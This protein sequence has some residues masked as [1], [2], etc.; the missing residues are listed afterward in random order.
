MNEESRVLAALAEGGPYPVDFDDD[1]HRR[2]MGAL[3]HRASTS[4]DLGVLMRHLLRRWMLR[5]GRAVPVDVQADVS[6]SLREVAL[7][8]GLLETVP[9]RWTASTWSPDW[10]DA[11]GAPCD[12]AALAGTKAGLRFHEDPLVADPFFA[13]LTPFEKYRTAG[14]RAACRAAISSPEGATVLCMLPTGSGKT[15]I[16]LTLSARKKSGVTVIIV[17]T[18]ALAADF[19][20]RFREHY[21]QMYPRIKPES[22]HF[23]WTS[24]TP[25][26]VKATMKDLIGKGQQPIVVTSPESM[27]RSL[28]QTMMWAAETGRFRGFVIDEAHLVSQWGRSFRPEFRTLAD[29]RRDLLN[30]AAEYRH[31]RAVT[32]LLSATLGA[33][34]MSDLLMLFGEPGP[35]TPIIANALRAEPDIWI[36]RSDNSELRAERV[37]EALAHVPR[38]AVLYVTAPQNADEWADKLRARGY[39][40]IAVVTGETTGGE[41]TRVLSQIR[42]DSPDGVAI[43]LVVATSAFGLGIDYPGIR[44]V[45]HACLPETVDRW[46]QEI[47]RGG[48]DGYASAEFL[49]TA[50][51]DRDEAGSLAVKI[52]GSK[53]SAK[54]WN[55]LWNHRTIKDGTD[56]INLEST[57]GV[58]KGDYNR[59]W[60]AQLI[61]GLVELRQLSRRL[62]GVDELHD[63][64][65][66]DDATTSDWV[67]VDL[68]S[69]EL[70]APGFWNTQWEQWRAR[71]SEHSRTALAS[72]TQVANGSLRACDGIAE[73]YA[74]DSALKRVWADRLRWMKPIGP[75]GRCPGCR[76]AKVAVQV[77]PPPRPRQI[78]ATG[79]ALSEGLRSFAAAARG[80]HGLVVLVERP[81][82]NLGDALAAALVR[83]GVQHIAGAF[84]QLPIPPL[85]VPLFRDDAPLTSE[86]LAPVSSFSRFGAEDSV[87]RSWLARR[88]APRR[89]AAGH[90]LVDVLLVPDGAR[91][92]GT[93]IGR[94]IPISLGATAL[95]LLRKA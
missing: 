64:L 75:C 83:D 32:L 59:F 89:D 26:S 69:A 44:S 78:W 43:D 66:G 68:I 17:P 82:E 47:G 13:E 4:L 84:A 16:A 38:P 8:A 85:G 29:F 14:Q 6:K 35:F 90:D 15:E 37:F 33:P 93:E 87:S 28:R 9:N 62:V 74:P 12:G 79:V 55:N 70:N 19:E 80:H 77:D 57:T 86:N 76:A 51:M 65:V 5:D 25:D 23:A 36:A 10:L 34:E 27:T 53:K 88:A 45:V 71:E 39:G 63:L 1:L 67:A 24:H 81:G 94:E 48:R 54:R 46:Y 52:L 60:N 41:R 73:A 30:R 58:G 95:E 61:Q 91:I 22:L 50:P 2:L 20:R 49:L 7:V 42:A 11:D 72:M 56:Y 21:A 40:R 3:N 92:G 18:S 31:D